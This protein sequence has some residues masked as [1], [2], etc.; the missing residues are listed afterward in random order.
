M[1][2]QMIRTAMLIGRLISVPTANA[3]VV[4]LRQVVFQ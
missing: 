3:G 2:P 4:A 1:V